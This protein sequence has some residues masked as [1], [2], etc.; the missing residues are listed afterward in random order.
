ME[1]F[2]MDDETNSKF[3]EVL[4][5]EIFET[6]A[7]RKD[8]TDPIPE[9]E[10]C[11][12]I[13]TSDSLHEYENVAMFRHSSRGKTVPT[14]TLSG[15]LSDTFQLNAGQLVERLYNLE[16]SNIDP[17]ETKKALIEIGFTKKETSQLKIIF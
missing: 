2:V 1:G 4:S 11:H 9:T 15:E 12:F 17:T 6:Q 14:V 10:F 7:F 5:S 16:R 3:V 13:T 8:G